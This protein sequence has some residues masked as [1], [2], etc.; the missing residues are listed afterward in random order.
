MD[1]LANNYYALYE[2]ISANKEYLP[3]HVFIK[4]GLMNITVDKLREIETME[5][6]RLHQEEKL[7]LKKIGM[8]FSLT[9][10]GVYRRIQAF[11]KKQFDR[12]NNV[13]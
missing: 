3:E 9:D 12:Q 6:K 13:I 1:P 11:D 10:S 7:S 2:I 8:I 4:Y 5:M